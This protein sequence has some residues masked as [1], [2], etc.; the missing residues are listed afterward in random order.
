MA[1]Y[2]DEEQK[3]IYKQISE[4]I[5]D[6]EQYLDMIKYD[7]D[8]SGSPDD[9]AA[10]SAIAATKDEIAALRKLQKQLHERDVWT[11]ITID[12]YTKQRIIRTLKLNK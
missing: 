2:T 5:A 9:K 6:N 10:R 8:Y 3:R 11:G 7:A 4:L 12:H 1:E